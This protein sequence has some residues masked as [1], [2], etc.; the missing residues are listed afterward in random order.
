MNTHNNTFILIFRFFCYLSIFYSIQVLAGET[1]T[2]QT[3]GPLV[4]YSLSHRNN[5]PLKLVIDSPPCPDN[6]SNE[7]FLNLYL[8]ANIYTLYTDKQKDKVNPPPTVQPV[9]NFNYVTTYI[10]TVKQLQKQT[11]QLQLALDHITQEFPTKEDITPNDLPSYTNHKLPHS[12]AEE[13]HRAHDPY[14]A[15]PTSE[16]TELIQQH[17]NLEVGN[18]IP[19][20]SVA[21]FPVAP[22]REVK[23]ATLQP[24]DP[25]KQSHLGSQ[26][27]HQPVSIPTVYTHQQ[28]TTEIYQPQDNKEQ[29]NY[30]IQA[31]GD[32]K[33]SQN[34]YSIQ[35]SADYEDSQNATEPTPYFKEHIDQQDTKLDK[36]ATTDNFAYGHLPLNSHPH[37]S[38]IYRQEHKQILQER[39]V[40]ANHQQINHLHHSHPEL[41]ENVSLAIQTSTA[42][43]ELLTK[44]NEE[45]NENSKIILGNDY[46]LGKTRE[47]VEMDNTLATV[48]QDEFKAD[49][50]NTEKNDRSPENKI[51]RSSVSDVYD[52][53]SDTSLYTK[54]HNKLLQQ[55]TQNNT[56]K[57]KTYFS[58]RRRNSIDLPLEY[59]TQKPETR[60]SELWNLA[61]EPNNP[62][63]HSVGKRPA[64]TNPSDISNKQLEDVKHINLKK[65]ERNYIRYLSSDDIPHLTN[66]DLIP[67]K[68]F[69][70]YNTGTQPLKDTLKSVFFTQS[71]HHQ[72]SPPDHRNLAHFNAIHPRLHQHHHHIRKP[73]TDRTNHE[74]F[75]YQN[76]MELQSDYYFKTPNHDTQPTFS[77][78]LTTHA[79]HLENSNTKK[80][81]VPI[82]VHEYCYDEIHLYTIYSIRTNFFNLHLNQVIESISTPYERAALVAGLG[83]P[84]TYCDTLIYDYHRNFTLSICCVF[85]RY[86]GDSIL[87][88][89]TSEELAQAIL[90]VLIS[91]MPDRQDIVELFINK[92]KPLLE[93]I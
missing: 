64:I 25:L 84:A 91:H 43:E 79:L 4:R 9:N 22:F 18:H 53:H 70:V 48:T 46:I 10:Q 58:K 13:I 54:A 42:H 65:P 89:C 83:Y 69:T 76:S 56:V 87:E 40:Q 38:D 86:L 73:Q 81:P 3:S 37:R 75:Q 93:N 24:H 61:V 27:Q 30:G 68:E 85:N 66:N 11:K 26:K 15:S 28:D 78:N 41:Q 19:T 45:T 72:D 35:A 21:P 50:H 23:T 77:E 49:S 12:K 1:A 88:N 6:K 36:T 7:F 33:D 17:N 20:Q 90:Q 8:L 2:E 71:T 14:L 82:W 55:C 31:S 62:P 39:C 34:N 52:S 63:R 60:L 57:T 44:I 29:Y 92:N 32:G 51:N 80:V 67:A 59:S 5:K 16:D 74:H 47:S